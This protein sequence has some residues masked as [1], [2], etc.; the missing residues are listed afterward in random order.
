MTHKEKTPRSLRAQ[1]EN[2]EIS[3][4]TS[5]LGKWAR[6][7]EVEFLLY[8]LLILYV[9]RMHTNIYLYSL[10]VQERREGVSDVFQNFIDLTEHCESTHTHTQT[11]TSHPNTPTDTAA[12]CTPHWLQYI[13]QQLYNKWS[14]R[15]GS[16]SQ[17][18]FV[19]IRNNQSFPP[20]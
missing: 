15:T 12:P 3:K 17:T 19:I 10:T 2:T 18:F 16:R 20:Q 6:S 7:F 1:T 14:F 4:T 13:I 5:L 9:Q 8:K 11:Y